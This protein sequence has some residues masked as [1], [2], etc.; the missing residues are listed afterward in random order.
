MCTRYTPWSYT[1][2]FH[3]FHQVMYILYHTYMYSL[4]HKCT[5][6]V[7][8]LCIHYTGM[9][10]CKADL[11]GQDK[12]DSQN[13]RRTKNKPKENIYG[14]VGWFCQFIFALIYTVIIMV[15]NSSYLSTYLTRCLRAN[16][17]LCAIKALNA[18]P[19]LP[20][21]RIRFRLNLPRLLEVLLVGPPYMSIRVWVIRMLIIT[22][23]T[24]LLLLPPLRH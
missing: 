16:H 23:S 7:N 5:L 12:I 11:L 15:A 1:S 20:T 10:V 18:Q 9:I 8:D 24:S 22:I 4:H 6:Y 13:R 17:R 19:P 21:L 14:E 2:R 3:C